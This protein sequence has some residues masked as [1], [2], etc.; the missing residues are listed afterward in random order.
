MD[1]RRLG[2]V[3][4]WQLAAALAKQ[5]ELREAYKAIEAEPSRVS[6][7]VEVILKAKQN[8]AEDLQKIKDK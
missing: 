8:M 7:Q 3:W 5:D 2:L 6:K 1:S 4:G